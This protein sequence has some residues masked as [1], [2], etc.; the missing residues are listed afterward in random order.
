MG[1]PCVTCGT[2]TRRRWIDQWVCYG[3]AGVW[4]RRYEPGAER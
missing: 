1:R 4:V 2:V 3:C